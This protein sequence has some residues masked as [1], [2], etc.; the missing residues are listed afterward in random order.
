MRIVSI[1]QIRTVSLAKNNLFALL[2]H[3]VTCLGEVF[4]ELAACR[5]H[6]RACGDPDDGS[7]GR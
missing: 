4:R 1:R 2:E 7:P 5:Q 3:I 6:A